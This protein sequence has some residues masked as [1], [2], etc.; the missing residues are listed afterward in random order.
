MNR[1]MCVFLASIGTL[2]LVSA[3]P[4]LAQSY[5]PYTQITPT[6]QFNPYS[7]PPGLAPG[8]GPR[9]SPFLNLLRGGNPAANYYLGVV[10]EQE[11]RRNEAFLGS[12]IQQLEQRL[13][14]LPPEEGD[15]LTPQSQ[16]G[17]PAVFFNTG[18]YF[19]STSGVRAPLPAAPPTFGSGPAKKP[20]R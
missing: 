18:P 4:A 15:L 7:R 12:S 11:R 5:N 9:L 2:P 8:G 6:T 1:L 3:G 16:T 17:H 20:A 19:A 14:T 10:P 13:N